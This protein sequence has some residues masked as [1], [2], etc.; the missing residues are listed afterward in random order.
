MQWQ[1]MWWQ[2]G[3]VDRNVNATQGQGRASSLDHKLVR[4]TRAISY[5][6]RSG[7]LTPPP[8]ARS[9]AVSSATARAGMAA[10][11]RRGTGG[12]RARKARRSVSCCRGAAP[13]R[14]PWTAWTG[15]VGGRPRR[16]GGWRPPCGGGGSAVRAGAP[17]C[18]R[19][20][21]SGR[22]RHPRLG[23]E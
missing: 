20:R 19:G 11:G 8:A 15:I 14:P 9:T 4:R 12:L 3:R 18:E 21:G 17:L 23:G 22:R 1:W 5:P 6:H 16:W 10:A 7:L 2:W 13:W